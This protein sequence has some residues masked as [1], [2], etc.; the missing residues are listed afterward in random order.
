MN[1]KDY[2]SKLAK[3]LISKGYLDK[4]D[5]IAISKD[6]AVFTSKYIREENKKK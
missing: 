1:E 4:E 6:I 5:A 2:A 3:L